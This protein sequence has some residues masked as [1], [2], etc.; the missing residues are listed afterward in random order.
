MATKYQKLA[1]DV[2][3]AIKVGIASSEN[4]PDSGSCSSDYV[5]VFGVRWNDKIK[6]LIPSAYSRTWLGSKCIM[7]SPPVGQASRRLACAEVM[8]DFLKK[9]GW[10]ASTFYQM[11]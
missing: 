1:Q 5:A 7:I 3:D 2:E 11:D 4:V 9:R 6:T 10:D 8:T